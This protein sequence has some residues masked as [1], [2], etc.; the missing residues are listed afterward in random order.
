MG[1][2]F[3]VILRR[4]K[5]AID[6]HHHMLSLSLSLSLSSSQTSN[7]I[8]PFL[9]QLFFFVSTSWWVGW[10]VQKKEEKKKKKK[11]GKLTASGFPQNYL[12]F[13]SV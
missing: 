8:S 5:N 2:C 3:T 1:N 9:L 11:V 6:H 4:K 7:I 12:F 10:L 13:F